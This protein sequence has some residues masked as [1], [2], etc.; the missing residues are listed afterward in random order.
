MPKK[1]WRWRSKQDRQ[2][3][4]DRRRFGRILRGKI[5]HLTKEE[6]FLAKNITHSDGTDGYCDDLPPVV[7]GENLQEA[8]HTLDHVGEKLGDLGAHRGKRK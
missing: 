5:N 1:P 8:L 2:K 3:A 6:R 4:K 7:G